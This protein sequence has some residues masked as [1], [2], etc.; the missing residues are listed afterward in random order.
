[1]SDGQLVRRWLNRGNMR[2]LL[3]V[4]GE[5]ISTVLETGLF[6]CVLL[7]VPVAL[8]IALID[9]DPMPFLQGHPV[10]W[11]AWAVFA[12]TALALELWGKRTAADAARAG[13]S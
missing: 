7:L 4:V 11:F 13:T 2:R 9:W 3:G 10:L 8:L 1:M 12:T 6:L 5:T